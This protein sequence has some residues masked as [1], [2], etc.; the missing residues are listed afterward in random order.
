METKHQT[1]V[2][3]QQNE[4]QATVSWSSSKKVKKITL[5][6]GV[7]MDYTAKDN[8]WEAVK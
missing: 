3:W 5:D 6:G 2:I 7:F 8:D 4:K 1:P